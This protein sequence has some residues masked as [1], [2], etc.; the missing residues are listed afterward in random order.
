MFQFSTFDCIYSIYLSWDI[1][2][3]INLLLEDYFSPDDIVPRLEINAIFLYRWLKS[4]ELV[5][6]YTMDIGL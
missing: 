3:F 2:H 4:I 1:I 5:L 6:Y